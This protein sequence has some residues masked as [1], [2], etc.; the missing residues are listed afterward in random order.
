MK[1][2][3]LR[4]LSREELLQKEEELKAELYKLNLQRYGG[5]VEKPH[6]FSLVRKDIARIETILN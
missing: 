2:D 3:Q 5:R 4:G 6:R 1:I